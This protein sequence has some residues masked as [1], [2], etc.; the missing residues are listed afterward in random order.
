[1]ADGRE[2]SKHRRQHLNALAVRLSMPAPLEEVKE[3]PLAQAH[4]HTTAPATTTD[5]TSMTLRELCAELSLPHKRQLLALALQL[6]EIQ[7]AQQQHD[8][9]HA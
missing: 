1:M 7:N 2:T 9:Q 8:Y 3:A 4:V 6:L 5:P